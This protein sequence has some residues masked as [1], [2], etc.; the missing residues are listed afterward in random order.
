M[1]KL[2]VLAVLASLSCGS[3]AFADIVPFDDPADRKPI[4]APVE[5]PKKDKKSKTKQ[6]IKKVEKSQKAQGQNAEKK[7]I[8]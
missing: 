4:P 5:E 6:E 3:Q 8:K 2:V 1:K 7:S